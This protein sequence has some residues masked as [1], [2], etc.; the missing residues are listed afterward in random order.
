MLGEQTILLDD[1]AVDAGVQDDL[2]QEMWQD[3]GRKRPKRGKVSDDLQRYLSYQQDG[4]SGASNDE[5]EDA[6]RSE[7]DDS[8][9]ADDTEDAADVEDKAEAENL[10]RKQHCNRQRRRA[11]VIDDSDSDQ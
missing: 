11:A 7:E 9:E 2:D 6:G 4:T 3:V 8:D 5:D 10:V 1:D